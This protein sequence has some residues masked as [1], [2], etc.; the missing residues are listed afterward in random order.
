MT[1]LNERLDWSALLR[2]FAD[3]V[4]HPESTPDDRAWRDGLER[5]DIPTITERDLRGYWCTLLGDTKL[6]SNGTLIDLGSGYGDYMTLQTAADFPKL[7]VLMIDPLGPEYI[8][9]LSAQWEMQLARSSKTIP[10]SHPVA[11]LKRSLQ[12]GASLPVSMDEFLAA[13]PPLSGRTATTRFVNHPVSLA[14]VTTASGIND[15]TAPTGSPRP[16]VVTAWNTGEELVPVALPYARRWRAC[17][18]GITYSAL[19]H[20]RQDDPAFMPFYQLLDLPQHR[21]HPLPRKLG[22]YA[23]L[24]HDPTAPPHGHPSHPKFD[25][26]DAEQRLRAKALKGLFHLGQAFE[27]FRH[28][29]EVS[30]VHLVSNSNHFA[31][32]DFLLVGRDRRPCTKI[33]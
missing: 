31:Q 14:S 22:E 20:I 5:F 28:G 12:A 1:Y 17:L 15:P 9:N 2:F 26:R 6:T 24:L 19:D 3:T 30:L 23:A 13:Y 10:P 29:Y 18:F 21:K 11:L 8:H 25:Y 16:Y 7:N 32:P 4:Q 27:A 33:Y